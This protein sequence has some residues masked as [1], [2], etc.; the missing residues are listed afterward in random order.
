MIRPRGVIQALPTPLP[1]DEVTLEATTLRPSNGL[2]DLFQPERGLDTH[3]A[4]EEI[5]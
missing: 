5:G 1:P 4:P 2:H 3:L